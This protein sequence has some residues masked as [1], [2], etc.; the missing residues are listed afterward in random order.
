MSYNIVEEICTGQE[1]KFYKDLQ[2]K[3]EEVDK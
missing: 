2:D 3:N 1:T